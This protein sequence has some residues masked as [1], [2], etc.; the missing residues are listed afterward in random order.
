MLSHAIPGC[1]AEPPEA[2]PDRNRAE[3]GW[4]ELEP[5]MGHYV[6]ARLPGG[7]PGAHRGDAT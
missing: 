3:Q 4:A 6:P 7:T 1:L 2:S 5:G